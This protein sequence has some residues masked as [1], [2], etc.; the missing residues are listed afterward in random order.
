MEAHVQA[1][2]R[3]SSTPGTASGPRRVVPRRVCS[4][5]GQVS[6]PERELIEEVTRLYGGQITPTLQTWHSLGARPRAH[7]RY[8]APR[9]PRWCR[10]LHACLSALTR[11]PPTAREQDVGGL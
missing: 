7:R 9:S 2:A 4:K 3:C 11:R 1:R 5:S 10:P 8:A 6:P